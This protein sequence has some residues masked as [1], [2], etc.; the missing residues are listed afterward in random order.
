MMEKVITQLTLPMNTE[1]WYWLK[2]KKIKN[3]KKLN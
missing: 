3:L 2:F 1:K